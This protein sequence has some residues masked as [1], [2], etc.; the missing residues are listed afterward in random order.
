M[1]NAREADN[2]APPEQRHHS[3]AIAP[4]HWLAVEREARGSDLDVVGVFHSH[5][6]SAA[7]PSETDLSRAWPTLG[8]VIVA[9]NGDC[10]TDMRAWRLA[11]DLKRFVE[12]SI[13]YLKNS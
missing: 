7:T 5:P 10:V 12:G 13:S 8:Y 9:T 6:T 4:A 11:T 3:Y 1:L 2:V